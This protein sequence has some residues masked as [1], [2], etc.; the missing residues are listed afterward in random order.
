MLRANVNFARVVVSR[1]SLFPT[2]L[3]FYYHANQESGAL[4]TLS[5]SL[6]PGSV[7]IAVVISACSRRRRIIHSNAVEFDRRPGGKR[8]FCRRRTSSRALIGQTGWRA[9]GLLC[10]PTLSDD[11]NA[12]QRSRSLSFPPNVARKAKFHH[13]SSRRDPVCVSPHFT[14]LAGNRALLNVLDFT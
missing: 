5:F 2:M 6:S 13:A 4:S 1:L 10:G 11:S 14:Q 9:D 7:Q 3:H 12:D 8:D